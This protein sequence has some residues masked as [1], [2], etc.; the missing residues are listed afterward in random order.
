MWSVSA[1]GWT[2]TG[3]DMGAD[4]ALQDS[5]SSDDRTNEP[6]VKAG[7]PIV[8]L[9][10]VATNTSDRTL[11]ISIDEP[12]LWAMPVD[13]PYTQGVVGVAP[14]TDQQAEMHGVWYHNYNDESDMSYPYPVEPGESCAL[15]AVLPLNLG[16]EF[17]F[18]PRL[19][20][21]DG[22]SDMLVNPIEFDQQTYTFPG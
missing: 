16:A 17:V 3:Y 14:A 6:L 4:V 18:V 11:Y 8:F 1:D 12:D 9:N 2:V 22:P 7:D 21:H 10:V 15:G 5:Y 20:A 19:R 13:T